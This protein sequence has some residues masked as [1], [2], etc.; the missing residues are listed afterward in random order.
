M[1]NGREIIVFFEGKYINPKDKDLRGKYC[2]VK[3]FLNAIDIIINR[4]VIKYDINFSEL[5]V[6]SSDSTI[7]LNFVY[8]NSPTTIKI[9]C[10]YYDGIS[11]II[12]RLAVY[13]ERKGIEE[14]KGSYSSIG[15]SI[16]MCQMDSEG[17]GEIFISQNDVVFVFENNQ[18]YF[19]IINDPQFN[20]EVTV[21]NSD[22]YWL[23]EM[24]IDSLKSN[25]LLTRDN[26][27]IYDFSKICYFAKD[28]GEDDSFNIL[29]LYVNDAQYAEIERIV[30]YHNQQFKITRENYELEEKMAR[31]KSEQEE[32]IARE[33]SEQEEKI[34]REKFEQEENDRWL[35]EIFEQYKILNNNSQ[36]VSYANNFIHNTY[37]SIFLNTNKYMK[38]NMLMDTTKELNES[39]LD[40]DFIK[41]NKIIKNIFNNQFIVT[42]PATW[43][44]LKS[45]AN[46]FFYKN[47]IDEYPWFPQNKNS[48]EEYIDEYINIDQINPKSIHNVALFTYFLMNTLWEGN[49][50]D[51][52]DCY[53]KVEQA[54]LE[55]FERKEL[56][57]FEKFLE[58]PLNQYSFTIDDID[59][60]SGQ[61]FEYFLANLFQKMGYSTEIT[62]HSGDQGID[63][64]AEKN[65]VKIGIQAKCYSRQVTNSA[66]Q[67]VVA[68]LMYYKLDKGIVVTNHYFTESAIQLAQSNNIVLWDRNLLKEKMI[69]TF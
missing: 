28:P 32:R 59:L 38:H 64:I 7:I 63:V 55:G 53:A 62:K 50:V 13:A 51:F 60:M 67:E 29:E 36:I 21:Y 3:V 10:S 2:I 15:K 14:P 41:F 58:K 37:G 35:S 27:Y 61:D 18:D 9:D 39:L 20:F 56:Y 42:L 48:L 40:T 45:I 69:E 1:F 47:F 30:E 19:L 43:M 34:A 22:E 52:I 46:K 57:V 54:V 12:D 44:F 65:G 24:L 11:G 16:L 68:G 25:R 49:E 5:S 17:F 6:T 26:E 8:N 23:I 31:E 66:V 33:K 4:S